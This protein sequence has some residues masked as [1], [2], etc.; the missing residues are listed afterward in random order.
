MMDTAINLLAIIY[1]NFPIT[2]NSTEK[3]MAKNVNKI[4]KNKIWIKK[5]VM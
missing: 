1:P 3:P 4:K 2:K 5:V